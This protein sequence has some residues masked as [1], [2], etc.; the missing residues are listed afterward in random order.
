MAAFFAVA[1]NVAW[2]TEKNMLYFKTKNSNKLYWKALRSSYTWWTKKIEKVESFFLLLEY[3]MIIAA[4]RKK[5]TKPE[6]TKNGFDN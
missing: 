1:I 4:Y 6:M 2:R 5:Y 3:M